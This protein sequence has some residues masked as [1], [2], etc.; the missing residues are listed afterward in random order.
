[1]AE[2]H[3]Q[4]LGDG[5]DNFA[6]AASQMTAAARQVGQKAGAA[7]NAGLKTGKTVAN[8]LKGAASAGP[9]GA[10]LSAAWSMRHTLYRVLI[11]L[12]LGLLF[13]VVT[14]VSL[15]SIVTNSIFGLDGSQ[16]V[17][18]AT[19][20][21]SYSEMADAVSSVVDTGYDLSLAKVEQIIEDGGYD[22]KLSMEALVNYGHSSSGYDTC[23][24][25]A[26]YSASMEQIGTKKADM[27][28]KLTAVA[29]SMFPVTYEEKQEEQQVPVTY[30]TYKP[31]TVTII[32]SETLNS[33]PYETEEKTYYERDEELT[34]DIPVTV[35]AYR[36]VPVPV[37]I[38]DGGRIIGYRT[39]NYYE[40][41]GTE[42]FSPTIEIIPYVEC[43]I[44][45][46]DNS[47]I[48]TAFGIDT[49]A[50]YNQFNIT[51]GEA[52]QNMSNALKMTLYGSL[53]SGSTVP[54]TDAELIAF[55]NAQN[56]NATRK[57]ILT[58]ALSLVGKVPYF[59]GGKSPPG[60]DETWNTPKLVTS[61]G[62]PSTGTIRPYG[63]DCSGFTS[64]VYNTSM[65]IE[66]G[67]GTSGQ[68]PNTYSI[69]ADEL[70]P[71]DLAFLPDGNGWSHVLIFAGYSSDGTRM[72]VHSTSGSGVTFNSPSYESTLS[73]R[74]L[75]IV[76]YDAP[77]AGEA[78]GEP[79][80]EIEV[81]VTHY[82]PCVKCCGSNSDGYVASG[83]LAAPGMV[84]MSSHYPFG[85]QI[86]IN[87]T[88]YTVEDRGGSGIENNVHRVDIFVPDHQE[89]LRLGKYT[90]TA[91]IYRL[92]W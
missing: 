50:K 62:S 69:S 56:C 19:L 59:W 90:T 57:Y 22:Y 51:Y 86:L 33:G 25:L 91:Y 13:L 61:A 65:G 52:I 89:A 72:W 2:P 64:W 35:P 53:G 10:A 12:C 32:S 29:G 71:G 75:S 18:G 81:I 77:V 23:Y 66:I 14:I 31:V 42:T 27:L 55:V 83:K 84:A 48:T 39:Q 58:T 68:F 74:R 26:A 8:I 70:L 88:M 7:V 3:N 79:L 6:N 17:E 85:T 63:L 73:Y 78:W 4:Q 46:F 40:V 49:S 87:G 21:D 15:P 67:A 38:Y 44:H 37:P 24:V 1:M 30:Y 5:S 28:S 60:W 47:V 82:C 76:D 54:L 36:E 20:T 9:Y 41:N 11:C 34:S 92:G 80:Y 43:T 16:P 45:P